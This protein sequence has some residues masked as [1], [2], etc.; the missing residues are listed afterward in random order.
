MHKSVFLSTSVGSISM[1]CCW[2]K[3]KGRIG[4]D[5]CYLDGPRRTERFWQQ[6]KNKTFSVN[7]GRNWFIPSTPCSTPRTSSTATSSRKMCSCRPTRISRRWGLPWTPRTGKR[8]TRAGLGLNTSGSGQAWIFRTRVGP[9]YFG[10]G[11]AGL[12]TSG[13]AFHGVRCLFSKI[14]YLGSCQRS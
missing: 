13:S 9:E 3:A 14:W 4:P 11:R 8:W 7:S 5:P 2:P 10:S 6:K 12:Y 1:F